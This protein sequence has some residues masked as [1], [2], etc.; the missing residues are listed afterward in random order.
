MSKQGMLTLLIIGYL[1]EVRTD[2]IQIRNS[3]IAVTSDGDQFWPAAWVNDGIENNNGS[4]DNCGCCAALK[5]PSWL[6]L[7]LDKTYLVEKILVLGRTDKNFE[8]FDNITLSLGR[9]DQS[10]RNEAL[11]WTNLSFPMTILSPPREV[12]FVRVSGGKAPN[13][14]TKVEHWTICEI[15]IYR[16]AVQ[17]EEGS[18]MAGKCSEV[19][20]RLIPEF[21][22]V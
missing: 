17:Q 22:R 7:T 5:R 9:Q 15:M 8:Q 3:Q 10:L 11:I 20:N 19:R 1:L 18:D 13:K 4:A 6:Q 2:P 16:Q 21:A 14:M 12:D